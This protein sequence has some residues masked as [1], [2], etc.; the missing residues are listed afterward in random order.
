MTG[1]YVAEKGGFIGK[2]IINFS[3][4]SEYPGPSNPMT[5]EFISEVQRNKQVSEFDVAQQALDFMEKEYNVVWS[6]KSKSIL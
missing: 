4:S 3:G 2:A 1:E 5:K 6:R